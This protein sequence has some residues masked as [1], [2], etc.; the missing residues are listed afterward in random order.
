MTLLYFDK[1]EQKA[2]KIWLSRLSSRVLDPDLKSRTL[3]IQIQIGGSSSRCE[4][5]KEK[6]FDG[7]FTKRCYNCK[8]KNIYWK[9]KQ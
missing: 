7:Y 8:V 6:K 4:K 1:A 9:Y 2:T 5:E 3:W